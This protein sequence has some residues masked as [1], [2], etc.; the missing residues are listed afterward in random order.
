M[1]KNLPCNTGDAGLIPGSGRSFGGGYGNPHQYSCLENPHGQRSLMGY[2]PCGCKRVGHN[3]AT[4]H[5]AAI[6]YCVYMHT[7]VYIYRAFLVR[8]LLNGCLGC[9]HSLAMVSNAVMNTEVHVSLRTSVFVFFRYI[10]RIRIAGSYES[11][12]FSSFEELWYC[13]SIT[14]P[15]I[16]SPARVYF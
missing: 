3:W 2:S 15:P 1:V 7:C 11:S 9:F 14:A 12:V 4:K 8:S 13:F 6:F 5:N 16:A 10:L